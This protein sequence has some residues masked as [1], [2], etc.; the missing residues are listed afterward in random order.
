VVRPADVRGQ[1]AAAVRGDDPQAR[2]AVKDAAEDQVRQ[3]DGVLGW[4]PDSVGQVPA[5]EPLVEGAAEWL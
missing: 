3:R 2:M 5:V 4:L 1:V